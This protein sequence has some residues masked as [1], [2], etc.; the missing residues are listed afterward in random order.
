MCLNA[1]YGYFVTNIPSLKI[2][3]CSFARRHRTE[4]GPV[5][6]VLADAIPCRQNPRGILEMEKGWTI[7]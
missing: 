4:E 6:K 5:L 2:L 3:L 7:L 1:H